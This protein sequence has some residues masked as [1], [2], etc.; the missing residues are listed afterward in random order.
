MLT[1]VVNERRENTNRELLA[2]EQRTRERSF[3]YS[4]TGTI[5]GVRVW[6]ARIN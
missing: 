6:F 5:C 2:Q 4:E 1:G 3:P